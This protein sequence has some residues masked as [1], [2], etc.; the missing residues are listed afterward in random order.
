MDLVGLALEWFINVDH[1]VI[2]A[3]MRE[4]FFR[5]EGIDVEVL[6]PVTHEAGMRLV[7][8]G[9]LDFAITEPIHMPE[10]VASGLRVKAI[11]KYFVTGFGVLAKEYVRSPRDFRGLRIATPLG[12]YARVIIPAM[13]RAAGAE[14]SSRDFELVPVSYYLT[15]A[16]LRNKADAA[17]AAFE[18][19]EA[20]E[21]RLHGLGVNFFRFTDYGVPSYGYLVFVTNTEMLRERRDLVLRFL[22]AVRRGVDYTLKN[23]DEAYRALVSYVPAL[24][25]DLNRKLFEATIKCFTTDFSLDPREWD[26]LARWVYDNGL[27]DRR[28][29]WSD[30][31]EQVWP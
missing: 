26:E 16:L 1:T 18:N 10:A 27:I 11:G 21:A 31:I 29:S 9:K 20:V 19:Y 13:A 15:D 6:E 14:I 24:D 28:L 30:L 22:R 7:A 2:F 17:F 8:S 3:A 23:P 25:N 4:G 5:E 12:K